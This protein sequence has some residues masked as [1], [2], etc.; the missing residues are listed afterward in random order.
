[1]I[2][3]QIS[4]HHGPEAHRLVGQLASIVT[5]RRMVGEKLER[6]IGSIDKR[7]AAVGLCPA[8]QAAISLMSS[9]AIGVRAYLVTSVGLPEQPGRP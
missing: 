4:A 1:V 9:S 2:D 6:I 3:D 5:D 8:I 7:S